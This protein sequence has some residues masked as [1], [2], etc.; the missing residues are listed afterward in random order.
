[1]RR[2]PPAL[3]REAIAR[4][5]SQTQREQLE[6]WLL[7]DRAECAA[8]SQHGAPGAPGAATELQPKGRRCGTGRSA[9]GKR[10]PR[11]S[12]LV[13]GSSCCRPQ[14]VAAPTQISERSLCRLA[15]RGGRVGYR[16]IMHLEGGFYV[17]AAFSFDS[18]VAVRS[19]GTLIVM[20]SLCRAGAVEELASRAP[21]SA[22]SGG[23]AHEL[24]KCAGRIG[25]A[26]REALA[27]CKGP[28]QK[29]YFKARANFGAG[30]EIST[31][32]RG[33]LELALLDWRR[34]TNARHLRP[35]GGIGGSWGH[36]Q[37][38]WLRA[39]ARGNG[40]SV[41][42]A[43]APAVVDRPY[44]WEATVAGG[45]EVQSLLRQLGRLLAQEE[46]RQRSRESGRRSRQGV[47]QAVT[48][49]L[50]RPRVVAPAAQLRVA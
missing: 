26:V 47:G 15:A 4:R 5:L 49:E 39:A 33:D 45:R 50:K 16:P 19:L 32:A 43:V 23:P 27:C 24:A 30:S 9:A 36:E 25:S 40:A 34:L 41:G 44:Q 18:E 11:C 22:G 8:R 6:R 48:Q 37:R 14:Q 10:K 7:A 1:L 35:R 29:F 12:G 2:L 42:P 21:S 3:R 20:R 13:G 28:H 31:P 38:A 17:Q 46:R